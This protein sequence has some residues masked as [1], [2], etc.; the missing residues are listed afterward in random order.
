VD[1][2]VV[3]ATNKDLGELVREGKFRDDLYYRVRV[4]H[5]TLPRLRER[6]EDIPLLVDHLV[7]KFRRLQGKNIAG[8][9]DDVMARLM[10]YDFPGN[11][12]ELENIIEQAFV[13]CCGELIELHHL[14]AELRPHEVAGAGQFH[15]TSLQAMEKHLIA[16]ALRRFHG[17]RGRAARELGIDPSTMYRKIKSLGID[18]PSVDGRGRRR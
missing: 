12:R 14:P 17:N 9:S 15:P 5:L 18:T 4:V 6:R 1:V 16:E 13:L 8:V 11:I 7:T 10:E 3:A 2:R